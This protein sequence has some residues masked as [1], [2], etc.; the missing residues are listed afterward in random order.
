MQIHFNQEAKDQEFSLAIGFKK[1][2][3]NFALA[4]LRGINGIVKA[5]FIVKAIRDVEEYLKPPALPFINYHHICQSCF[6]DLDERDDNSIR[7]SKD[8]DVKY[9]HR[10]C[11][12]LKKDRPR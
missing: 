4:V 10:V 12:P 3:L 9:K 11:S 1:S 6:R 7:L 5:D 2:E 8:A